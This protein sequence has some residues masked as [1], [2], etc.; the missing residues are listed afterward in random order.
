MNEKQFEGF[1]GQLS[2]GGEIGQVTA[3][4]FVDVRD[5]AFDFI[6]FLKNVGDERVGLN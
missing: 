1:A 6:F 5:D 2:R 4:G 3:G